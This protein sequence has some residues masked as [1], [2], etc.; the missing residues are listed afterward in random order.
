MI[1]ARL[2]PSASRMQIRAV[3]A[4]PLANSRLATLVQ[5]MSSTSATIAKSVTNSPP[6]SRC[7][8][9]RPREPEDRMTFLF[10][11]A[12][13]FSSVQPLIFC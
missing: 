6:V 3:A 13:R 2:A 9:M 10:K 5:A 7:T 4:A 8:T 1:L 11:K 12:C